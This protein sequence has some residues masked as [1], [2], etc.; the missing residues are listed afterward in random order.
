MGFV[1]DK[2]FKIK[3]YKQLQN[4]KLQTRLSEKLNDGTT[5]YIVRVGIHK[6]ILNVKEDNME[7][8]M[9]LC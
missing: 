3:S 6:F 4:E 8:V 9:D 2:V 7:Y 5:R 1:Q